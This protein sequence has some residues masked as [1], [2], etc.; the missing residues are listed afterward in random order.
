MVYTPYYDFLQTSA[1]IVKTGIGNLSLLC[2]YSPP[3]GGR[4]K[5]RKLKKII[6]NL[7]KPVMLSGDLNS[8]HVTF[9]CL[10][11]NS[12]GSDLHNLLDECDL[13]ILNTG[14]PT[15]V[16]TIHHKPSAID[17]SCISPTVAP[18][19]EWKVYDDPMGSYHFPTIT[20][21]QTSIEKYVVGPPAEHFI[22]K[23]ADWSKYHSESKEAFDHLN[24]EVESPI[25]AYL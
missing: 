14:L 1:I 16:G 7:P 21:I 3:Q 8:H 18:S 15:T 11:T 22:Y 9:G 17:I 25:I 10:S 13:C 19:C 24:F 5:C 12:R 6:N 23:Q 4:F 2:A 20:N